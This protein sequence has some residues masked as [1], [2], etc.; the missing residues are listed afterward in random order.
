MVTAASV[1]FDICVS[2]ASEDRE[3]VQAVVDRLLSLGVTV[4]YDQLEKADL[5]GKD[6]Y[7]YLDDVYRNKATY[8]VI[9]ISTHYATKRWTNHERRSAQARALRQ[10]TEYVLPARFDDIDVPGLPETVGYVDLNQLTPEQFADLILVKLEKE[11]HQFFV[12]PVLDRLAER[13]GL[14]IADV[15]DLLRTHTIFFIDSME[16]MS[17]EERLVVSQVLVHGCPSELP[18]NLHI[19]MNY[20]RRLSHLDSSHLKAVLGDLAPLGF[21]TRLRQ[22]EHEDSTILGHDEYAVLQYAALR[23]LDEGDEIENLGFSTET[24]FLAEL[25][26]VFTSDYCPEHAVHYLSRGDLSQLSNAT[27]RK[28]GEAGH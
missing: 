1:E 19:S 11:P 27:S 7:A 17:P 25:A 26:S 16:K 28:E 20:L 4:F 9:F 12:P 15:G 5:W 21:T 18:D 23:A 10:Q 13:I 22:Q 24:E 3:Y 6:L 14:T 2:Y 8:C